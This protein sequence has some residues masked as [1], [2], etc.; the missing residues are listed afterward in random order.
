MKSQLIILTIL[1]ALI[2]PRPAYS[3]CD[4]LDGP[5]VQA[6]QRALET[7][8]VNL[9]LIW[10][11]KAD[12]PEIRR[13]FSQTIAVRTLNEEAKRLADMYFFETL[14][15]IHRAGEGAPYTGLK[16]AGRDLGPAIPAA[17]KAVATGELKP[18]FT[19]LSDA[20]HSGLHA[21]WDAVVKS[22]SY[23]SGNIEAGRKYVDAYVK[24]LHY[25]EPVYNAATTGDSGSGSEEIHHH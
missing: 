6:A 9:I 18:V 23:Q 2:F 24:F 20:V 15:R 3:H 17:D 22:K 16:A 19:L 5:V 21:R 4:G 8:D 25:V 10:V 13:A 11:K 14:V 12:E 7:N 1:L